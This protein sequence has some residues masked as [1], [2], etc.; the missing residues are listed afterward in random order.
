[1]KKILLSSFVLT[2]LL[3]G[4]NTVNAQVKQTYQLTLSASKKIVAE[5]VNYAT[6]NQAPG[7]S[8]A[9]VDAG[10]TVIY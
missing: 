5:A 10:G 4:I 3:A 2:M 7:G 9:I 8:I 6:T 1:M